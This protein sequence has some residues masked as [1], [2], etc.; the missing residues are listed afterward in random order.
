MRWLPFLILAYLIV[1]LQ[2]AL[3]GFLAWGGVKP[4]LILPVAVFIVINARREEA[5]LGAFILGVLQD[6]PSQQPPGLYAFSYGLMALFMVGMRSA[7]YRDHLLTHFFTT[8]AGGLLVGGVVWLNEW[9][10][11]VL[12]HLENA[13]RP[14]V[15]H[16]FFIAL[17]S[18]LLAP[19][20]LAGL[21]RIKRVFGFR[22]PTPRGFGGRYSDGFLG[23]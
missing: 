3:G 12:Q 1:A 22:L 21:V 18:A 6:L 16:Q 19:L 5:L 15:S 8:F 4:N 9:A 14:S 2:M 7:L 23:S 20:L 11:P 13:A 17:Y 10:R